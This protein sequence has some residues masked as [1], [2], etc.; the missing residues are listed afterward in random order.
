MKRLLYP[1]L[2]LVSAQSLAFDA[3]EI[4]EQ[5]YAQLST[6]VY[7]D[8]GHLFFIVKQACDGDKK[9]SGTKESKLAEKAF[10]QLLLDEAS[11]RRVSFDPSSVNASGKLKKD[12]L[13]AIGR[14][15]DAKSLISHQL[16]FDRDN[17]SCTRE[18]VQVADAGQFEQG[19]IQVPSE[20]AEKV[21]SQ[22]ILS[23][24]EQQDLPLMASY[25]QSMELPN[26]EAVYAEGTKAAYYAVD[27][28]L[29]DDPSSYNQFCQ[30]DKKYCPSTAHSVY[31]YDFNSVLNTAF[32]EKGVINLNSIHPRLTLSSDLFASAKRNFDSGTNPSQIELDL[33]LS[34]NANANNPLA[35]QMLSSL[36]RATNKPE[37]ALYSAQ[38]FL[39][40]DPFS[41]ES[42]VYLLTPLGSEDPQQAQ[43]LH[44][45]L[46]SLAKQAQFSLWAQNQIK[47][48]Q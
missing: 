40:Q 30:Q 5:K 43:R 16:I 3:R 19:K 34:L 22:L 41:P 13:T 37:L 48:Y 14:Q 36:Y 47:V 21:R 24:M 28:K 15:Y 25:M 44:D 6:G 10:Y 27:F 35:W 11:L 32:K 20:A 39:S 1:L 9:Y 18:Y 42:W 17:G 8:S 45:V 23:A 4:Y 7:E 46:S 12:V 33:T 2:A 26:L 29:G 31:P 38:Q